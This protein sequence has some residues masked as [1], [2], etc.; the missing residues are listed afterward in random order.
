MPDYEDFDEEITRG[1]THRFRFTVSVGGVAQDITTWTNFWFTA[2]TRHTDTTAVITRTLGS[3]I[4]LVT[5]ASGIAQVEILP[6]NTSSM[7]NRKQVLYADIQGKDA[8]GGVWTLARGTLT[9]LPEI[10]TASS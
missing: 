4:T 2:R 6:A 3:G 9:V 8:T 7:D 1:D 5:P 10:T